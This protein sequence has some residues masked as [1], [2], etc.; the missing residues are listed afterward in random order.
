MRLF[1]SLRKF[2]KHILTASRYTSPTQTISEALHLLP[3]IMEMQYSSC[4]ICHTENCSQINGYQTIHT[5][6]DPNSLLVPRNSISGKGSAS[7]FRTSNCLHSPCPKFTGKERD[8]EANYDYFGARYYS[9]E[10]YNWTPYTN[11]QSINYSK[12]I[13]HLSTGQHTYCGK[14]EYMYH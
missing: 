9:Y 1:V 3:I 2:L 7:N 12:M 6:K 13:W 11:I 10:L 14:T 8:N 4:T 5:M